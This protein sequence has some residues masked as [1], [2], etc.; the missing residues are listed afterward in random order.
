MKHLYI[1]GAG[2]LGRELL[3]VLRTD[4]AYGR[5][6]VVVGFVD[7]RPELKHTE[8]DEIPVVGGVD[9]V[10]ISSS[11]IFAVAIGNVKLKK[12]LV[13]GLVSRGGRFIATRTQ[14]RVGERSSIGAAV[15]QLNAFVSVDCTV[16]DYVYLDSACVVGHD[17]RIGKYSHVG[18]GAFVGGRVNIGESV[19][20]HPKSVIGQGITIGDGAKIGIG[21]VVMKNVPANA[22]VIGN[23]A[24]VVDV[25]RS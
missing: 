22:T 14:C 24:R 12:E 2:G 11:S 23:P 20:I 1:L 9:D 7:S 8:I 17:T 15:F 5:Q 25:D 16:E 19:T 13:E 4:V 18:A 10:I 21:A 3:A 6:W